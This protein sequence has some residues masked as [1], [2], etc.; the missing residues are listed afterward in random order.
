MKGA[1][2]LKKFTAAMHPLGGVATTAALLLTHVVEGLWTW[3][4]STA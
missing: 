4:A 1:Q 2:H 3:Q